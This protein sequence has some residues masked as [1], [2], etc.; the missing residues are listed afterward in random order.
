MSRYLSTSG[1][2]AFA[3]T[4]H[5]IHLD[6]KVRAVGTYN[7]GEGR[8]YF[9]FTFPYFPTK[10][11]HLETG[12][13]FTPVRVGM[14]YQYYVAGDKSSGYTIF[15]RTETC[16]MYLSQPYARD[17]HGRVFYDPEL[18]IN[19]LVL[20]FQNTVAF[21]VRAQSYY[22]T[23]NQIETVSYFRIPP[24]DS[25]TAGNYGRPNVGTD[26][27][28]VGQRADNVRIIISNDTVRTMTIVGLEAQYRV[29]KMPRR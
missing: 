29:N 23:A 25:S 2:P 22:G 5:P 13:V 17:E 16:D 4:L 27:H 1:E 8:T 12:A 21:D 7:A 26:R 6:H 28:P 3:A 20:H 10:A 15:G 9:S 11:V 24:F 18:V 14:S 19:R